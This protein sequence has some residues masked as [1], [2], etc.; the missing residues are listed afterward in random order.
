MSEDI[1]NIHHDEHETRSTKGIEPWPAHLSDDLTTKLLGT[2][3]EQGFSLEIIWNKM[4]ILA[5]TRNVVN[6]SFIPI[7]CF[8]DW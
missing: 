7:V 6:D 1:A 8:V 4:P 3:H 5:F 2:R